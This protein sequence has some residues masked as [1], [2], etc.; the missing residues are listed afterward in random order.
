MKKR[1]LSL[2]LS[3]TLLISLALVIDHA[4]ITATIS[5]D[6]QALAN[7]ILKDYYPSKIYFE[8]TANR[9]DGPLT[10]LKAIADGKPATR[11]SS[12]K[13]RNGKTLGSD[14]TIEPIVLDSLIKLADKYA[15]IQISM[16][17]GG[18]GHSNGSAHYYGRAVD[19][20]R[21]KGTLV[22]N[23]TSVAVKDFRD[24]AKNTLG[25]E[26]T[27][28]PGDKGHDKH[29]HIQW[30]STAKI[31]NPIITLSPTPSPN[32][33]TVNFGRNLPNAP[34]PLGRYIVRNRDGTTPTIP[35]WTE[36]RSTGTSTASRWQ[37][38]TIVT[39]VETQRNASNNH[40]GRVASGRWI[41]SEHLTP[42][43][44]PTE[45]TAG[46]GSYTTTKSIKV[47]TDP[48]SHT[49]EVRTLAAN[50]PVQIVAT[51]TNA[52]GNRWGK[53][54]AN[55]WVF[56]GDLRAVDVPTT[57]QPPTTTP[58]P[59]PTPTT[60]PAPTPTPS[61]SPS[62]TPQYQAGNWTITIPANT[63]V[64]L[65]PSQTS[66]T[67]VTWYSARSA[68][69]NLHAIGRITMPNGSTRFH[70]RA[71]NTHAGGQVQDLYFVLTSSMRV[72]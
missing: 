42:Y 8:S 50:A 35:A 14:A 29:V 53:I 17:V 48:S 72:N 30:K 21:I 1:I 60:T 13:D 69:F 49:R 67:E 62:P 44:A 10:N 38:G 41:Y 5:A 45:S 3:L 66:T 40:W 61:P 56:M 43:I 15:P 24:Y 16:I 12:A 2:A 55:E 54:K 64:S 28:G 63:R 22:K 19:I 59:T 58:T 47:F 4:A 46:S 37:N 20:V 68:P 6:S 57:T 33:S 34:I 71:A 11:H 51:T 52:A 26:F 18:S 36:P 7:I 31:N 65:F 39:I 9:V 70:I 25:A 23:C 32:Q 27:L